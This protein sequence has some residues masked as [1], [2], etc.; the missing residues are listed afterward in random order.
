MTPRFLAF[1]PFILK[2][3]TAYNKDGSVR[4]EHDPNDPGG[5]TR[6]GIDKA[7]HKRVDVEHLTKDGAIA[8]Y[9]SEWAAEGIEQMAANLGEVYYNAAVN[10]G[11][12]RAHKLIVL[13]RNQ[14][15]TFLD[16]QNAFYGRLVDARPK[17]KEYLKGWLN[18]TAAL[19]RFLAI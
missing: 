9:W 10:C 19:R 5:A 8:V 18:R 12:G 14:A 17:S 2:W 15:G 1:I 11:L 4:T 16:Q 7:S 13:S 6:Y 3:E